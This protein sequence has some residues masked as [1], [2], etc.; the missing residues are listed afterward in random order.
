MPKTLGMLSTTQKTILVLCDKGKIGTLRQCEALSKPLEKHLNSE[1]IYTYVDL[2]FWFKYLTPHITRHWPATFLP[3]L[4]LTH[5]PSLIVAAGRQAFLVA[6]P[7]AKQIPTIALLNPRCT[8]DYFTVVIPPQHDGVEKHSNVIET[9]GS[10]HPHNESTFAIDEKIGTYTITVL[11][12]G[13]SKHYT[14]KENDFSEIAK[15]VKQKTVGR[16]NTNILI[17]PS[18]RTPMF[19]ID[20]LKHELSDMDATIWDGTGKNP[21]FE[22][23]GSANE[24]LVTGDSISMISEACYLGKPVE[25]WKLPIKNERF[26]RFYDAIT[27]NRHAAFANDAWPATFKPL[28]ELERVLPL[29][30]QKIQ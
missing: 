22:Y 17:S 26:L 4:N 12:G 19:G 21:Y 7:L 27:K 5:Q 24:I 15:Y 1:V 2:P 16:E 29:I 8:P 20:I 3:T 23:I 9:L 10:L 18:R 30:I 25:I 28:R 11:L 13:N 14:F 6:A